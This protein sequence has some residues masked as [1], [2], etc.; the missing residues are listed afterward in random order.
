M[1]AGKTNT[2]PGAVTPRGSPGVGALFQQIGSPCGQN[3]S[4]LPAQPTHRMNP[5]FLRITSAAALL[6]SM[7]SLA[8]AHPGHFALD[9]HSAP[10]HAG[11]GIE[12][13]TL[14][15][16]LAITGLLLAAGASKGAGSGK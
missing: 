11:H 13:G 16:A 4:Y 14:L 10:P 6:L 3:P 15:L 8:Q 9:W 12:Y 2:H 7:T 5:L 1:I